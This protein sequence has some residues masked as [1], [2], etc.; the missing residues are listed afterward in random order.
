MQRQTKLGEP[1]SFEMRTFHRRFLNLFLS[2][3]IEMRWCTNM[4]A[5]VPSRLSGSHGKAIATRTHPMITAW[6]CECFTSRQSKSNALRHW[7]CA[8]GSQRPYPSGGGGHR[9]WVYA[10]PS[11]RESKEI[12]SYV[13]FPILMCGFHITYDMISW[14]LG[15][16]WMWMWM[17]FPDERNMSGL[18]I[19]LSVQLLPFGMVTANRQ[20]DDDEEKE[21]KEGESKG[22]GEW[23]VEDQ[24][25]EGANSA[26]NHITKSKNE[27]K[28]HF[29]WKDKSFFGILAS[30]RDGEC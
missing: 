26:R 15:I 18:D 20:W 3:F 1:I 24:T 29:S 14:C 19:F 2:S 25:A 22:R 12:V 7:A 28:C 27:R 8:A 10:D 6:C 23:V 16:M 9:R 21:E 30:C 17:P 11:I 13:L 5:A 4:L